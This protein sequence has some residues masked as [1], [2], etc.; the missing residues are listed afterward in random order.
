MGT[1]EKSSLGEVRDWS[2]DTMIME[3]QFAGGGDVF[4]QGNERVYHAVICKMIVL[5]THLALYIRLTFKI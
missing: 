4:S 5:K 1:Q 3:M 2:L